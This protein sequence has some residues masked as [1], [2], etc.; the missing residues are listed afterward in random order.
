M[1]WSAHNSLKGICDKLCDPEFSQAQQDYMKNLQQSG[2]TSLNSNSDDHGLDSYMKKSM[3]SP[4]WGIPFSPM[5]SE[6]TGF[7]RVLNDISNRHRSYL[8]TDDA[9]H[10][11]QY[12]SHN[13]ISFQHPA[14]TIEPKLDGE[15]ILVHVNR[16]GIVKMH[17]RRGNWYR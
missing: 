2:S 8:S 12:L 14:F 7:D 9:K 1:L 4:Q 15:R 13:S 10:Y 16:E 6:R 17:T 11:S 3:S 5:L